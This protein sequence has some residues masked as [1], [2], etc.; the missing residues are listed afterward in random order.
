MGAQGK[1]QET[2]WDNSSVCRK[3]GTLRTPFLTHLMSLDDAL[4]GPLCPGHVN[5]SLVDSA[6]SSALVYLWLGATSGLISQFWGVLEKRK[7]SNLNMETA[8]I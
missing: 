4:E 8:R 6:V 1:G 3:H 5:T 2:E 7:S